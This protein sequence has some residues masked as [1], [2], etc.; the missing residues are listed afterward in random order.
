MDKMTLHP[1]ERVSQTEGQRW[2]AR[3][4]VR[5]TDRQTDW[6]IDRLVG[7]H[8]LRQIDKLESRLE[9]IKIGGQTDRRGDSRTNWKSDVR[10]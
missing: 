6:K 4:K 3:D 1:W 5:Q 2:E 9:D 10:T 8:T 7:I